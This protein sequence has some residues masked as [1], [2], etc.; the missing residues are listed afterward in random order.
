MSAFRAHRT[1]GSAA[2]RAGL[3]GVTGGTL[4]GSSVNDRVLFAVDQSTLSAEA[5]GTLNAQVGWLTQNPGLPITIEGH[6]D[7][8]GTRDYNFQLGIQPG[9][10]RAQLYGQPG[11]ARQPDQHHHL[12]PRAA[13]RDLRRGKLLRA[14]PPGCHGCD[15]RSR[16]LTARLR[17]GFQRGRVMLGNWRFGV[18]AVGLA[19]G[20]SG[21]GHRLG[22]KPWRI[23]RPN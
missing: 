17:A 16:D 7:E 8:R 1:R 14:E 12:W 19:W 2:A 13:G 4:P 9:Q 18:W 15:W 21:G 5:I 11:R 20:L 10:R 6:A 23:S 22:A 3:G